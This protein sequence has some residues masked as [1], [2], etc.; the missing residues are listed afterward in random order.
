MIEYYDNL[1]Q[2]EQE[3]LKGMI[4]LLYKQTFLL[5]RK[6][7]KRTKRLIFTKEYRIA[8]RHLE[9]LKEYL[10]IS[11]IEILD[12]SQEGII[13]IQGEELIG[14]K[15]PRLATFYLLLLKLIYEEQMSSASNSIHIFTNL[16]ELNEKLNSFRLVTDRPSPTEMRRA[17]T[18][19]KKYQMI[20]ILDSMEEINTDIRMLIYPSV[21][22]VLLGN[23]IRNLLTSY[24]E[25][26]ENEEE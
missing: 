16:G 17:L 7:D 2:E 1:L 8:D 4:K 11:G 18:L 19:L 20:E 23:Q 26:P 25:E 10:A 13:Y 5:E 6:Y 3:E 21:K 22:M 9:F 12:N 24:S 15:L 14:E